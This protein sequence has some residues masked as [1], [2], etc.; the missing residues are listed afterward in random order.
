M[1]TKL[2][3][4][5]EKHPMSATWGARCGKPHGGFYEGGQA[6][7]ASTAR[8][9]PTHHDPFLLSRILLNSGTGFP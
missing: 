7:A 3:Q 1:S 6:Q 2:D 9:V 5:M 8:P 4:I